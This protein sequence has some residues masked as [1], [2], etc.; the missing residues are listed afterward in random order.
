LLEP[1]YARF[2]EGFELPDL[3]EAHELLRVLE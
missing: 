3:R 1:V 2:T